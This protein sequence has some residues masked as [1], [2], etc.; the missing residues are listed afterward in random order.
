MSD[1]T[2]DATFET[3]MT[4]RGLLCVGCNNPNTP[5]TCAGC[6]LSLCEYCAIIWR[7][8]AWCATCAK[9]GKP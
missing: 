5:Y 9:G 6:R 7:K 1:F 3:E 4:M 8:S 2:P